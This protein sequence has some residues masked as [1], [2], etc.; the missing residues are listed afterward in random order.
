[1]VHLLKS[2][3]FVFDCSMS[4]LGSP[5]AAPLTDEELLVANDFFLKAADKKR[6]AELLAAIKQVAKLFSHRDLPTL[7]IISS[8]PE[9]DTRL[10]FGM[11]A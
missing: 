2:N 3:V 8:S 11:A 10:V 4:W 5:P 6:K 7:G 9:P 1:M